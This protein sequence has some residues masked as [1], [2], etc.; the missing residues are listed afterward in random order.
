MDNRKLITVYVKDAN[1]KLWVKVT[2]VTFLFGC[3]SDRT[4][5]QSR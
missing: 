1:G 2:I 4:C 3:S 5:P